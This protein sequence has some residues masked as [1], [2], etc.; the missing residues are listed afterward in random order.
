MRALEALME[1][2][3][4]L[5]RATGLELTSAGESLAQ[6]VGEALDRIA[7]AASGA[8]LRRYRPLSVGVY[9]YF[10]SRALLPH[11]HELRR[12][13]PHLEVDLHTSLNPLDLLPEHYD[14][15]IAVSDG[16]PRSG[17]ESRTLMPIATV[18]VCAAGLASR[19]PPDFA[20]VPMLHARPRPEDWRRWLNHAGLGSVPV[21]NAGS[22]ESIGLAIEAAAGGLG[23]AIGIEALLGPDLERGAIAVAHRLA[24]PTRRYFTLQTR[25]GRDPAVRDLADWL[26]GKFAPDG[27]GRITSL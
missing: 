23:Y 11:W 20:S 21:R 3:L 22:Y 14:A 9:G 8:R 27:G 26:C 24:R 10:A 19:D 6:S 16:T 12:A 13:C 7:E 2:P 25:M 1:T 5:R 18:P 15:V 4:F 17:V